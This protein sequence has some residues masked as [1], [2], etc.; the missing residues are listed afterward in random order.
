MAEPDWE[1]LLAPQDEEE[2]IRSF[3][4]SYDSEGECGHMIYEGERAGYVGDTDTPTCAECL[5]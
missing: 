4:A 5:P 1:S 2:P 3:I